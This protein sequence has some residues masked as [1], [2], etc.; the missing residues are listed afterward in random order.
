[1]ASYE[2]DHNLPRTPR[3]PR[4]RPA[5]TVDLDSLFTSSLP[6]AASASAAFR[7]LASTYSTLSATHTPLLESI[8]DTLTHDATSEVPASG[9]PE[10]FTD[11]LERVPKT[12]LKEAD[13][14]PICNTPF[15]ED[16]FPLVVRLPCHRFVLFYRMA[17]GEGGRGR[18]GR[19][20]RGRMQLTCGE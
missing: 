13:T 19:G 20:G 8:L 2:D 7:A 6:S 17:E 4:R 16:K 18:A 11:M 9:V 10:G 14:C 15:L 5:P 12:R 1:M 3:V